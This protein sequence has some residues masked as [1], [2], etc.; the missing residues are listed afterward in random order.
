MGGW[1]RRALKNWTESWRGWAERCASIS[2]SSDRWTRQDSK[3]CAP[4]AIAGSCWWELR[5][6]FGCYSEPG[7]DDV[8][9]V[10]LT[11]KEAYPVWR[12]QRSPVSTPGAEMS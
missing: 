4:C 1:T 5:D 7:H 6:I 8:V 10:G 9:P 11:S 12:A 2:R 3:R